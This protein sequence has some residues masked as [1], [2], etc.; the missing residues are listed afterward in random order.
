V[1][2]SPATA[3]VAAVETPLT[4][5]L[6]AVVATA[7]L[8]PLAVGVICADAGGAPAPVAEDNTLGA[9]AGALGA[10]PVA[11]A[12]QPARNSAVLVASATMVKALMLRSFPL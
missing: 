12:P 2:A 7:L 5:A 9:T 10:S 3:A 11:A 4:G 1:A 8:S 6:R